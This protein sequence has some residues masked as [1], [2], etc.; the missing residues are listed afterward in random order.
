LL[1]RE[2]LGL[3]HKPWMASNVDE[4]RIQQLYSSVTWKAV[5]FGTCQ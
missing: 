3:T 5:P 4:R 2:K 1:L